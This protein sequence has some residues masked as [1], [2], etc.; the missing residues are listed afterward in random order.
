MQVPFVDL[1]AQYLM[2]QDE[3]DAAISAVICDAAFIGGKYVSAF[4]REYAEFLGIEHC[5]GCANGT[6]AIEIILQAL[7]V[8]PGDEVIVPA[9][10][11]ISTAEAVSNIGAIPVFVDI[12]PAYYTI[13]VN[14]IEERITRNTKAIMPVHL[15]G[16]S[17]DMD[18]ILELAA[19]Y[20]L[21][22]VEDCAQAH[23]ATYKGKIVGT[24][25]DAATFSFYP[26]KNLG[27]Y[28]DA[29]CMV[30]SDSTVAAKARMIANHGQ[31]EKHRHLMEGRNSRLDGLQAAILSVKLPHLAKWTELRRNHA[32]MYG[33]LLTGKSLKIPQIREGSTHVFHLYVVQVDERDNIKQLL[34]KAGIDTAIHYPSVVPLL[35][36]Y[37]MRR[38]SRQDFPVASDTVRKILSLPMY[39]EMT[40]DMICHVAQ[41]LQKYVS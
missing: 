13:D 27:A 41:T 7:G 34:K 28:G 4:E 24:I 21:K 33:E 35:D 10:T 26:G 1:H 16:M 22:V 3:I 9:L 23:G 36:A 11:W 20:S 29:G 2:I 8:G 5:V 38:F 39:P 15:Y 6:D 37:K 12:D 19:R 14:R 30:T 40:D 17:A 32:R 25:G 31:L 18:M